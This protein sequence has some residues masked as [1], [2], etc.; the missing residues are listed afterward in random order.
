MKWQQNF[1]SKHYGQILVLNRT[2]YTLDEKST[3]RFLFLD[4]KEY[5]IELFDPQNHV[6]KSER[7]KHYPYAF[8]F[9]EYGLRKFI[10]IDIIDVILDS[11]VQDCIPSSS[12]SLMRCVRVRI[13]LTV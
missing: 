10:L 9:M 8:T 5:K 7:K 2:Q 3:T 4:D 1:E 6:S 13:I 12:Y 11:N